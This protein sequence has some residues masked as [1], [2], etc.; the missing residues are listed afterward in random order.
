MVG[1]LMYQEIEIAEQVKL[2]AAEDLEK[3]KWRMDNSSME[4]GLRIALRSEIV[5]L[6]RFDS[7]LDKAVDNYN[8][9][10]PEDVFKV[11][12]HTGLTVEEKNCSPNMYDEWAAYVGIH[13]E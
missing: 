8:R 9:R 7:Y 13:D 11:K 2:L 6:V 12:Y 4:Q 5:R 10:C 1:F 3:T